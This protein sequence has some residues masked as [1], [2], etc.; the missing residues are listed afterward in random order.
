MIKIEQLWQCGVL[1]LDGRENPESEE[2][3]VYENKKKKYKVTYEIVD[4]TKPI[5]LLSSSI[6]AYKGNN[7]NLVNKAICADNYDKKPNCYIE[8]DYDINKVGK[9]N[10]KYIAVD[11]NNNRN[12]KKFVLNVKEKKKS[13]NNTNTS[14]NKYLIK[15]LIKEHKN[16]K[17][18]IG[19]DVSSWQGNVDFKKVK[20][21]K[22]GRVFEKW[23]ICNSRRSGAGLRHFQTI[24]L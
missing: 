2:K 6:T 20:N 4:T 14:R 12:E 19:I 11:S 9:Y 23:F 5:I 17:T 8:G 21:P 18:M 7:V 24:C 3:N 10:L 1:W 15:D 22:G 16:D 13:N